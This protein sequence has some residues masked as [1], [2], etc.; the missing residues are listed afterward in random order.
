PEWVYTA[1]RTGITGTHTTLTPEIENFL[2]RINSR[3]KVLAGFGIDSP[4]QIQALA[5]KVHAPVVG[6][7]FVRKITSIW[8]KK[9]LSETDKQKELVFQ[10]QAQVRELTGAD[11]VFS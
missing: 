11:A 5:G 3:T 4:G 6:S 10:L 1:V 8:Q 9:D 7:A 2:A